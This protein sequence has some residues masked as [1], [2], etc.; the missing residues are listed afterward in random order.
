MSDNAGD[1]KKS[2]KGHSE[3]L[4]K[5]GRELS[6]IKFN[7][8]VLNETKAKYWENRIHNFKRYQQKGIGYYTQVHALMNLIDKEKAGIFLISL[9]KLHQLGT[10]LLELFEEIKQNPSIMSSKDKQQSKW[11]K[12]IKD[13]LI[14]YSNKAL[15]QETDMNTNF[16]QFYEKHLKN[17]VE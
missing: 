11:S 15:Q 3:N 4:A 1:L 13:Q 9:S 8:K 5:L 17:F 10:K 6:E 14:D 12:E 2:V 16:R 7:Y